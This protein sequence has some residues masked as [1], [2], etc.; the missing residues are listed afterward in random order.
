MA[1]W[2]Q[3]VLLGVNI[4][5]FAAFGLRAM[6][7]WRNERSPRFRSL[8]AAGSFLAVIAIAGSLFHLGTLAVEAGVISERVER[9]ILR[10][11]QVVAATAAIAAGLS[12]WRAYQ[13]AKT[14][15][16]HAERVLVAN[17]VTPLNVSI[18]ELEL[19]ARELEVLE[20]MLR[21]VIGDRDIADRLYVSPATV[22]SHVTSIMRKAGTR[23]RR[24]LL[25]VTPTDDEIAL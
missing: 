1:R 16:S 2:I 25:T 15:L 7:L 8:L 9:T 17:A 10:P 19:T 18:A 11:I 5:L 21:G 12:A 3:T 13:R 23:S 24:D 4:P 6:W 22:R 20:T 14:S